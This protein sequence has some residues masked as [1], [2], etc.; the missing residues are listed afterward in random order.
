MPSSLQS[1][2]Q[3]CVVVLAAGS[4]SRF[5]SPKQLLPWKNRTLLES[6]IAAA[7]NIHSSNAE[8]K[9]HCTVVLG[10]NAEQ[11]ESELRRQESW[12]SYQV[13]VNDHWNEGMGSSIRCAMQ[14]IE[15]HKAD[16]VLFTTCDQ[17]HIGSLELGRIVDTAIEREDAVI[18]AAEYESTK[19]IPALFRS[20]VFSE[21]RTCDPRFGAKGLIRQ[22]AASC[23]GVNMK[24]AAIDVD[25]QAD[26][27]A[28][29]TLD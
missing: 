24:E 7:L 11:I 8:L 4:S 5:G 2:F 29:N 15:E 22:Y 16:A 27:D 20:S 26:W 10:A 9:L 13:V 14:F 12:R 25:T 23:V 1:C 6:A 19:G 21:L 3:L 28:V 18:V 17:V